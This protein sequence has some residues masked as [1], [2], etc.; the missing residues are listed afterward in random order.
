[1]QFSCF[2][3]HWLGRGYRERS[4]ADHDE[5]IAEADE[6][7]RLSTNSDAHALYGL[8][9]VRKQE[10]AGGSA[11][12]AQA[13]VIQP[14]IAEEAANCFDKESMR[15]STDSAANWAG[16]HVSGDQ[17]CCLCNQHDAAS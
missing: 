13:K 6:T 12:I 8:A 9:K 7:L 3:R 4:S 16:C 17:Y 15:L 5:A 1:L 2:S 11:H 14:N 10:T